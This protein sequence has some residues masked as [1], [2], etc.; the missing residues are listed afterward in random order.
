MFLDCSITFEL[1]SQK[2]FGRAQ[3]VSVCSTRYRQ[4]AGIDA[5]FSGRM[6]QVRGTVRSRFPTTTYCLGVSNADAS[7]GGLCWS[8]ECF[9]EQAS[10]FNDL[11]RYIN[12]ESNKTSRERY[13]DPLS[14]KSDIFMSN[15]H[16]LTETAC[17]ILQ[18]SSPRRIRTMSRTAELDRRD[19]AAFGQKPSILAHNQVG[20]YNESQMLWST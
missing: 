2:W 9:V 13:W 20:D 18:S 17:Q 7:R 8:G 10:H 3:D 12:Q 19:L 11:G 16:M 5:Q 14:D 15:L 1:L 4:V 6:R